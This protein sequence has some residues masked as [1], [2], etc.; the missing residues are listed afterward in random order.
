MST[1]RGSAHRALATPVQVTVRPITLVV[2]AVL[3][4]VVALALT[5]ALAGN[6]GNGDDAGFTKSVRV[7][8]SAPIPPSPIERHQQPGLNGPGMRP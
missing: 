8:P 3:V 1:V 6:T 2:A 7:V 5:I 4:V